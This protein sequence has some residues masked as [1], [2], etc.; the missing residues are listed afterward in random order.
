M[1]AGGEDDE[2]LAFACGWCNS[3]KGARLTLYDIG[4]DDVVLKHPKLGRISVPRPFW[5][6]RLLAI[7][8][9]CE[10]PGGCA[11][12]TENSE[13][14]VAPRWVRG[15]MN[16]MNLQLTCA[17][18]DPLGDNRLVSRKIWAKPRAA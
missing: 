15:T 8:G 4:A 10:W 12:T 11:K 9:R 3:Q 17:E 7:R 16:P 1:A 5:I 13:L 18:H 14:T 6:V 2:N